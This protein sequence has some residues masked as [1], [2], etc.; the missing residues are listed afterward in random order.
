MA[1]NLFKKIAYTMASPF[2]ICQKC[3]SYPG[4]NDPKVYCER[5]KSDLPI[6][7]KGCICGQC[8]IWKINRFSEYYYCIIGKDPKS[9]I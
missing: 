4:K 8:P 2:C 5:A 7:K 1:G 3:P 9:R 6:E